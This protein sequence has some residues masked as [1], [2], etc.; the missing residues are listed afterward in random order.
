V[1][2]TTI[3][4]TDAEWEAIVERARACRKPPGRFVRETALG[5]L[6]KAHR[7]NADAA[8]IRELGRSGTALAHLAATARE[9]GALPAAATFE[10][11]LAELL[12]VVRRLGLG[13]TR[14]RPNDDRRRA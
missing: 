3:L 4:A 9:T 6:P 10:T 12:A 14:R 8:L 1:Q 13:R 11:T 2:R 7:S 5:A